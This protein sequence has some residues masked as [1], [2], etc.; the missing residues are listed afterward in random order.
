ML[1]LPAPLRASK[2]FD[3]IL[4]DFAS[5]CEKYPQDKKVAVAGWA[6][7]ALGAFVLA[8]KVCHTLL[9]D[10]L[11]GGPVQMIGILALPGIALKLI[12]GKDLVGEAGD[13][14]RSIAKRLPGLDK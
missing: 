6:A 8:E 2:D 14:V 13:Y 10:V 4:A 7:A 5:D 3:T 9:L 11:V 12:D 1:R